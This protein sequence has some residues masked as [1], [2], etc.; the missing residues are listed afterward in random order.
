MY[1]NLISELRN[2]LSIMYGARIAVPREVLQRTV[3]AIESLSLQ[4]RDEWIS[5]TLHPKSGEHVL[6]CCEI[7]GLNG[8]K[9]HYICEAFYAAEKS[10]TGSYDMDDLDLVYD[11]D[12]DEYY[13]PEGWYEVI[14]NWDEYE[15]VAIEDFVTHWKPL[16]EM[17]KF[18]DG[19]GE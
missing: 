13:W 4:T 19:D 12:A 10:I 2:N 18:A 5:A 1:E 14:H 6:A 9:R 7:R 16:P 15:A 8:K 17:P 3:E 11:E